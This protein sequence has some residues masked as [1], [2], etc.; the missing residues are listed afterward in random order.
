MFMNNLTQE[1]VVF[2][3]EFTR[4]DLQDQKVI[5][6]PTFELHGGTKSLGIQLYSDVTNDWMF[7][8]FT[9]VNETDGTEYNFTKEVEYY[10]GYDDEGSWTEG[11][12]TGEAFLS[13]IPEGRYHLNLYPEFGYSTNS[14]IVTVTHDVPMYVNFFITCII[15]LIFPAFHMIRQRYREQRRWRDSEY[16]PY[17]SEE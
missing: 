16:S 12:R 10:S 11:S 7:S 2:R 4:Q 3:G 14:F 5:V 17:S 9:L 6:T 1:Q 15:L 8:E 13:K